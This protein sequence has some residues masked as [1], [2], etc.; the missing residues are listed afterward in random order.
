MKHVIKI[1]LTTLLVI[2]FL[3]DHRLRGNPFITHAACVVRIVQVVRALHHQDAQ[4]HVLVI[5]TNHQIVVLVQMAVVL[6][7]S[8]ETRN[9]RSRRCARVVLK[10]EGHTVTGFT[11]LS[12]GEV[13]LEENLFYLHIYY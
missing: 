9:K 2:L 13:G 1:I 3:D 4:S 10:T 11:L 12:N 6:L 5:K 8:V 7:L